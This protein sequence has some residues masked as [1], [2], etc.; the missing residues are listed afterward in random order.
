MIQVVNRALDILEYL[1]KNQDSR[2]SLKDIS[3]ELNLNAGTCANIIKTLIQRQ[4]VAKDAKRDYLLG[5]MAY[6]LTRSGSY[7]KELV[8]AAKPELD[9]LTQTW[10][11]NSLLAIVEENTRVILASSDSSN[12]VQANTQDHKKAYHTAVGRVLISKLPPEELNKFIAKYGLPTQDEWSEVKK[13]EK[14]LKQHLTKISEQGYAGILNNEEVIGFAVPVIHSGVA[15]A[16]VGIY[17]PAFRFKKS[18][19]KKIIQSL[20]STAENIAKKL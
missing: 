15:V 12:N 13:S 5:S 4:Y 19:Q 7:K 11:E 14:L 2:N 8:R 16:G 1:S 9:K 20:I 3:T 10:N 17:M 18:Q 6:A